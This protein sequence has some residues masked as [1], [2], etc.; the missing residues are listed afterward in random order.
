LGGIVMENKALLLRIKAQVTHCLLRYR[1]HIDRPVGPEEE[2]LDSNFSDR[3]DQLW[4][5]R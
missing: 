5:D 1:G 4:S 2:V 3:P